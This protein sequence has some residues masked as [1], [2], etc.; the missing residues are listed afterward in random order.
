M[1]ERDIT[2]SYIER[3]RVL[4]EILAKRREV[5]LLDLQTGRSGGAAAGGG[6]GTGSAD[7]SRNRA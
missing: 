2:L 4:G 3:N 7:A 6:N 1:I 5:E